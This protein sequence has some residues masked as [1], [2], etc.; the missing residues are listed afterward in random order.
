MLISELERDAHDTA[1]A[2][3]LLAQ[4]EELLVM[5]IADRERLERELAQ[6]E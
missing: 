2:K 6:T 4:F 5:H 1:P 3:K